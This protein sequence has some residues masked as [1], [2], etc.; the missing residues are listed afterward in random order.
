MIPNNR[1]TASPVIGTFLYLVDQEYIPLQQTV[2][3]GI[4]LN[5]PSK[6]RL[7]QPWTVK[8]SGGNI[9][10]NPGAEATVF[11]LPVSGVTSVSLAFDNNM[12]PVIA[13]TSVNGANLYYYNTLGLTYTTRYFEGI[14]SCRVCVDNPED[15]YDGASDVI[16]GYTLNNNLCYRQQRD[17]YDIEYIISESSRIL[18]RMG[19]TTANRLQFELR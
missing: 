17:R 19:P 5:D 3:G 8:Y 6:G 18:S 13:W 12:S 7:Y 10:V 9:L 4:S 2:M 11:T 16:F 14:N 15:Y 1:F